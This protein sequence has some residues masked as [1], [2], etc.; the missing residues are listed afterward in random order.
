MNP[1]EAHTHK[2]KDTK[3]HSTLVEAALD[4]EKS[5]IKNPPGVSTPLEKEM[6]PPQLG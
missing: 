2:S 4:T 3:H 6:S 5:K 1:N